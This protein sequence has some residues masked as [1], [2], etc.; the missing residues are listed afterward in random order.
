MKKFRRAIFMVP[1]YGFSI[2]SLIGFPDLG[3]ITLRPVGLNFRMSTGVSVS[4]TPNIHS[5]PAAMMALANWLLSVI[6][7]VLFSISV[8]RLYQRSPDCQAAGDFPFC[9]LAF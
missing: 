8:R 7:I 1:K 6:T 4:A 2:F 3:E 9:S 5:V